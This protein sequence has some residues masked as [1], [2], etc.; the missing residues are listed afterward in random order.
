MLRS[1]PGIGPVAAATLSA[2]MPELGWLSPKSVAAMAGLAPFN[3][4]SGQFRGRRIIKGGRRRVREALYMAAVS[5]IRSAHRFAQIYK[6]MINAGKPAKV[7]I[8][9]I[10]RKILVTA[11]AIIRDKKP[12]H[13]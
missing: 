10:A 4:D 7:A 5:A 2:L 13:P 11:N 1:I 6:A 12:F 3:V 9:A 8:I